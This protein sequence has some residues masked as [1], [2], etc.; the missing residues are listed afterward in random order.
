LFVYLFQRIEIFGTT[1]TAKYSE[2]MTLLN[3]ELH[4]LTTAETV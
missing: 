3:S 1:P 4:L 2:G